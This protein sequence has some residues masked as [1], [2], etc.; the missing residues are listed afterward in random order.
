MSPAPRLFLCTDL[1]RTLLPNGTAPESPRARACFSCLAGHEGV[2]LAYVTGR[3]R[4]LVERAVESYCLPLPAFVISDVG[5][6][7]YAARDGELQVWPDWSQAIAPDWNGLSHDDL[8][9]LFADLSA[10]RVQERARQNV[11]KLSYYVPL[12]AD[13]AA[14]SAAMEA[15]LE[16]RGVRA[17]LVWSVDEPAGVG[18]LD[19]LPRSATKLDAIEFLRGRLGFALEETLYA[20]DSGN[21]LPALASPL[22]AVLVAN[23]TPEVREA[24]Q[25]Q[26]QGA[27]RGDALYLARGGFLDMNG[28]YSAGIL[29]G[30]AHYRPELGDWLA[31][32]ENC[33][34]P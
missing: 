8:R 4:A 33:H 34:G 3:H 19:I 17:S 23:A 30:V 28:N 21:D 15:R 25:A 13:R 26:A 27:G 24:A 6:N 9:D 5:T 22:P 14:L 2:M 1:D 20:G 18:L 32:Q 10:L 11:Y 16:R 7:I 12:H 29:E 31:A